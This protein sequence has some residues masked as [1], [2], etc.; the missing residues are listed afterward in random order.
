MQ[1]YRSAIQCPHCRQPSITMT[2]R[3]LSPLV[4]EIYLQCVNADCGHRFVVH[5]GV[6]RTLVPSLNP[7]PDISLPIVERSAAAARAA[8]SR[9]HA[10]RNY[11]PS[12]PSTRPTFTSIH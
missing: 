11:R 3:E 6:V 4:R 10:H 5:Q 8:P 9:H 7:S 1:S 2:S 12:A